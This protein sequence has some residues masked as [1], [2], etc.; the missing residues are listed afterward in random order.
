MAI[1]NSLVLGKI[2]AQEVSGGAKRRHS[3]LG[4]AITDQANLKKSLKALQSNAFKLFLRL[5][6]SANHY[7]KIGDRYNICHF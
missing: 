1:S 2:K 5:G 4:L 7:N 3:L 6:L